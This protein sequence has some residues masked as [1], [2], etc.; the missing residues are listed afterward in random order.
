MLK[1][2]DGLAQASQEAEPLHQAKIQPS[3]LPGTPLGMGWRT[4]GACGLRN[5]R[6]PLDALHR[7]GDPSYG[8]LAGPTSAPMEVWHRLYL[9]GKRATTNNTRDRLLPEDAIA[10]SPRSARGT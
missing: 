8:L 5:A 9:P 4:D 1:T 10:R 2:S 6:G 7:S 3:L